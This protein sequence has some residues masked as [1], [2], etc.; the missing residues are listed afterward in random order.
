MWD[1]SISVCFWR[2]PP[3]WSDPV[4]FI[5]EADGQLLSLCPP[6]FPPPTPSVITF[7]HPES[8]HLLPCSCLSYRFPG[9]FLHWFYSLGYSSASEGHRVRVHGSITIA[10]LAV[11]PQYSVDLL[12]VHTPSF[13]EHPQSRRTLGLALTEEVKVPLHEVQ[14]QGIFRLCGPVTHH[15]CELGTCGCPQLLLQETESPLSQGPRRRLHSQ[16]TSTL[17]ISLKMKSISTSPKK[18]HELCSEW[19]LL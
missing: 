1:G 9:V 2:E 14:I 19:C 17:K 12:P 4:L 6:P 7:G 10:Q 11:T 15:G 13:P 16:P 18:L 3:E 5:P 8:Y